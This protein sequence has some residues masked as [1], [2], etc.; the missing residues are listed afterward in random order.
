MTKTNKYICDTNIFISAVLSFNSLPD[1]A[2][3]TVL[4]SNAFFA[5][6]DETYN[7]FVEVFSR[8]KFNKYIS[9]E[10]R[11]LFI[12][13][14]FKSSQNYTIHKKVDLCRDPKDNKFLDLALVSD[15]E[16]II[17]GDEDL[18]VLKKIGK[19]EIITPREF[20]ERTQ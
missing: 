1:K 14:I 19:T 8:K 20:I 15:S 10:K 18:L 12:E 13:K 4:N 3:E 5:F 6:S 11:N 7:E 2:V 9:V 17:T 16:F